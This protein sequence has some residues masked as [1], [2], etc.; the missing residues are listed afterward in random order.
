[1]RRSPQE[2]QSASQ[3]KISAA[4]NAPESEIALQGEQAQKIFAKEV[5]ID[6]GLWVFVRFVIP[7]QPLTRINKKLMAPSAVSQ[8]FQQVPNSNSH[9]RGL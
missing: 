7:S 1:M 4:P 5:H 3:D 2:I 6:L 9:R 8:A